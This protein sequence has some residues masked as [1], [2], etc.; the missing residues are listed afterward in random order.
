[1]SKLTSHALMRFQFV[2][3][4]LTEFR[5]YLHLEQR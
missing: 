4:R 3:A 2:K 5:I 1:M